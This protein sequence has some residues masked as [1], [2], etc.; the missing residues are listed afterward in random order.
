M[1]VIGQPRMYCAA[2][3]LVYNGDGEDG[4]HGCHCASVLRQGGSDGVG[5]LVSILQNY[6]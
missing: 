5:L 4:E 2:A 3:S 1:F 6:I